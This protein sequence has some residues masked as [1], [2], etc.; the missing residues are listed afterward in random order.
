MN[1]WFENANQLKTCHEH[2][3]K[4]KSYLKQ[5]CTN[6]LTSLFCTINT[7]SLG[8][9]YRVGFHVF[10][11]CRIIK[12]I[13]SLRFGIQQQPTT[14]LHLIKKRRKYFVYKV[15]FLWSDPKKER[16]LDLAFGIASHNHFTQLLSSGMGL[17][18]SKNHNTRVSRGSRIVF[19]DISL[20][21]RTFLCKTIFSKNIF[22]KPF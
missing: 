16:T 1:A 18:Y 5:K 14:Q 10:N 6:L 21:N 20:M 8:Y 22:F 2:L 12:V 7:Q 4:R 11:F 3:S 19:A 17:K 9:F 13:K 15:E